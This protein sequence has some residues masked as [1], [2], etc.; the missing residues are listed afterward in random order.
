[1]KEFRNL[2]NSLKQR[3]FCKDQPQDGNVYLL[4]VKEGD[5]LLLAT[6]GV[7]DNLFENEILSIVKSFSGVR[8]TKQNALGIARKLCESAYI[9]S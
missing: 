9:K 2:K 5:L 1:M 6:D 4:K 8:K 7:F 3:T